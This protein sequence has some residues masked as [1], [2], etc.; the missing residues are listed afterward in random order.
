[1]LEIIKRSCPICNS[2]NRELMYHQNFHNNEITIMKSYDV[3]FCKKCGFTYAGNLP[4]Q[5]FFDKYYAELSKYEFNYKNGVA[6]KQY[7]EYYSKVF[8]FIDPHITSR[9]I[10]ILD[11]GC[12][13]G[14]LLS[15]FKQ[16]GFK[17]ITGIDP[18]ESCAASAKYH[19]DLDVIATDILKFKVPYKFDLFILSAVLEHLVEFDV[20]LP[21]INKMLNDDGLLFIEV[22]DVERFHEFIDQSASFQQFSTEHIN[23]FSRK[24]LNNLMLKYGFDSIAINQDQNKINAIT[25]PDI[26]SLLKKTPTSSFV[27]YENISNKKLYQYID[28]SAKNDIKLKKKLEDKLKNISKII[29]W[30]A[31]TLT[32]RLL[33]TVIDSSKILFFVDS[34]ERYHGKKVNGLEIKSPL[35][36][37]NYNEPILISSYSYQEEII[38]Q[39]KGDLMLNNLFLTVY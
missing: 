20:I 27:E 39:I 34:N 31:G 11:I 6:N 36:I 8:N 28:V 17:E 25:D 38:N 29:V 10:K 32:L 30:G 3:F 1:M 16:R 2:L 21:K 22:P 26:F 15:V 23:Y 14:G 9:N 33:D 7:I 12:S 18:S 19:Y 24:S 37:S 35:E 13:T 5:Q 4:K